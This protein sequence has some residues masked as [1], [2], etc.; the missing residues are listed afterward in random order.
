[1]IEDRVNEYIAHFEVLLVRAKW[2]RGNKGSI[3]T[4][5]NGLTKLV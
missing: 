1:M 2:N 3:N 4:F 5:F